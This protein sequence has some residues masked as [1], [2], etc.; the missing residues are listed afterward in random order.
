MTASSDDR[1]KASDSAGVDAAGVDAADLGS[2]GIGRRTPDFFIVGH[3]KSGTTA[4][5]EMLRRHPQIFMPELKEPWFFAEDMRARF[6]PAR[7]GAVPETLE[8]YLDLFDAA[9]AEQRAG[10]ASS[11]YLRS[12]CA[13]ERI[14]ALR[15]DAR[16]VAILREPASFLRS[17]H[18]QLL[19]DHVETKRD[20]REALSLEDERRAGRRIPSGSHLPQMLLYSDHVR[21]VEQLRRYHTAFAPEQVLVL[22]YDDFRSDN[23]GT[24]RRVQ[25]FL[26]VEQTPVE[27]LDANISTRRMRSQRLDDLVNGVS[28]GRG[29][30]S[31]TVKAA[32][33][34]ISSDRLRERAL[35]LTR[36]KLIYEAAPA[37][38]QRLMAELR[39]RFHGEVS[40]LSE[41]L[42]RDLVSLW[43]YQDAAS[44]RAGVR[45]KDAAASAAAS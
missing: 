23:A 20:L 5:Y 26:D 42:G 45:A 22:I 8:R 9:A 44:V 6:Q 3:P 25:R 24:L 12:S 11:S 29:P 17:L 37:V 27:P 30:L 16:I 31:R 40:A 38:D 33:K 41:Y 21:Y 18:L 35:H 14:A 10:E 13:A 1:V 32:V 19:R 36:R 43:G 7:S 28:V 15:A 4:L 34:T 2:S 39:A